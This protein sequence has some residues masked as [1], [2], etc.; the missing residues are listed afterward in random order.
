MGGKR[1]GRGGGGRRKTEEDEEGGGGR[2]EGEEGDVKRDGE[3]RRESP[4]SVWFIEKGHGLMP[5]VMIKQL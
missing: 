3:G 4:G 2:R 1:G 5:V